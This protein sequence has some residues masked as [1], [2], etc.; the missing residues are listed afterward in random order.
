MSD[1][2][3]C[4]DRLYHGACWYPE[5][6]D[7]ATRERDIALMKDT[8]ISV[9]RFGEFVWHAIESEEGRFDLS[10]Y[11][12]ALDALDRAGI[13]A[14][15]CTPTPT[16]PVW[17]S[18]GHPERLFVDG[19]G[20]TMT[21]GSR[22]HACTNNPYYRE[23]ARAVVGQIARA[24]GR[25]PAVIGWQLDN[26]FKCHV[27]ECM[28]PTCLGLW[29]GW[30]AKRYG[31]VA[32]LNEAWGAEVWSEAYSS[33]DE[34]PQPLPAPFLHNASLSTMYRLFSRDKIE[35]FAREQADIIRAHSDY[36]ITHNASVAF[37]LDAE[38]LFSAL[39]FASFDSYAD[40]GNRN[41]WLFN[42]DFFRNL[43]P[44]APFWVM[45]T[46]SSFAASLVSFGTPHPRGY[47]VAEAA[48]SYSLG[49]GGFCYW[50]WRQQRSGCEMP[51]SAVITAWGKP[52]LGYGDV[53]ATEKMRAEIEPF[54]RASE[55]RRP[56][57]AMT[58]SDRAK[59]YW[60]TESLGE[61]RYQEFSTALYSRLLAA[62]LHRDVIPEGADVAGY[63]LLFTPFVPY[64]PDGY[65]DRAAAL[66]R[67]G[68]VWVIGPLSGWRTGEHTAHVDSALGYLDRVTGLEPV[69][70]APTAK[71][72]ATGT[73]FDLTAPL[74]LWSYA[75]DAPALSAAL[76]VPVR[77]I[78]SIDSGVLEGYSFI[79]ERDFGKGKIVFLGSI[80]TGTEGDAMLER[81][82]LHY[83]S[84]AGVAVK[85]DVMP[86]SIVAPRLCT[87]DVAP[88]SGR[89]AAK[90][91]DALW[92]LVNLD[93][94]GGSVTL[95]RAAR[96]CLTGEPLPAGRVSV[97]RYGYRL[98]AFSGGLN[99]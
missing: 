21:H 91:G 76:S 44:G 77:P 54:M 43:R 84:V 39:D 64:L 12:D 52:D 62:G 78:G 57:V 89:F 22:Q 1:P 2:K 11:A 88:G 80:P 37:S 93:G 63:K 50:L 33:F 24:V 94:K 71:T 68:G 69:H 3:P 16:P 51:H 8:G 79:V 9:V 6:W 95:P 56:E 27:A 85:T 17:L 4:G 90:A 81:L 28:C 42:N 34:V 59:A 65:I 55:V 53:R 32:T 5:L 14:I 48:A 58:W 49:A 15:V 66:A 86:G 7:R 73:A 20:Q 36:P 25:H 19:A 87:A 31:D 72:G 30:L 10:L 45:E 82:A 18:H 67:D 46:S 99:A 60:Q 70:I 97:G 61:M 40:S 96:D 47:L 23:R 92:S 98:I 13:K 74:S 75:F 35:E 29:H 41:S 26:E 38:S 83:A